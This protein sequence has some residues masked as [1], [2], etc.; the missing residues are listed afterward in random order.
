MTILFIKPSY[1][2]QPLSRVRWRNR[3]KKGRSL[4]RKMRWKDNEPVAEI[5]KDKISPDISV[6]CQFMIFYP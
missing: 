4:W 6:T 3:D 2:E 1:F 5:K